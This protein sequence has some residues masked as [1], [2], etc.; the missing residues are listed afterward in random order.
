MQSR[1]INVALA[2]Y[3]M[4]QPRMPIKHREGGFQ[5]YNNSNSF[6]VGS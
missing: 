2:I 5:S 4:Q 3:K 6:S 1:V